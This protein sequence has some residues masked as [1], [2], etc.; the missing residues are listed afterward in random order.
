MKDNNHTEHLTGCLFRTH[1]TI[2]YVEKKYKHLCSFATHHKRGSSFG[3]SPV[4]TALGFLRGLT[5]PSLS[6]S[7]PN[8]TSL[9]AE[10]TVKVPCEYE[11]QS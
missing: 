7:K 9:H 4:T 2:C 5:L 1:S 6:W 11:V 10:N 3:H 8:V